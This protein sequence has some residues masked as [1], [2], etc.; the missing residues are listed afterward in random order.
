MRKYYY[1]G[2]YIEGK[3]A[4]KFV[5]VIKYLEEITSK[6]TI[7]L[8]LD[9]EQCKLALTIKLNYNMDKTMGDREPD[10]SWNA[11]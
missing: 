4:L 5:I 9:G 10:Y 11:H 2:I 7:C 6:I 1:I 8:G 3:N